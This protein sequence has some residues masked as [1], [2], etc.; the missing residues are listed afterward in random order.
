[1]ALIKCSE[2]QKE[3]SEKSEKCIHCGNPMIQNH[4]PTTI[5]QTNKEYKT[6]QLLGV[7]IAI[8]GIPVCFI[9]PMFGLFMIIIGFIL[10]TYGII[11]AWWNIG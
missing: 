9:E 5:E 1:M 4:K 2:C 11:S 7:L 8:V 6:I 10:N 3:I